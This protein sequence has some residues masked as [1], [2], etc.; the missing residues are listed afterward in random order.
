MRTLEQ[1]E[2]ALLK[3]K[4]YVALNQTVKTAFLIWSVLQTRSL[5]PEPRSDFN[6]NKPYSRKMASSNVFNFF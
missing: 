4:L 6:N 3:L 5:L 2:A 1:G